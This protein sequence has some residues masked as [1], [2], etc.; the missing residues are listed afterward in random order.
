[1]IL[2]GLFFIAVIGTI[3]FYIWKRLVK[4]TQLKPPYK[5]IATLLIVA[6]ALSIPATMVISRAV[7]LDIVKT[8]STLPLLWLG[9]MLLIVTFLFLVDIFILIRHLIGWVASKSIGS[10]TGPTDPSRRE[11]LRKITAA[12]TLGMTGVLTTTSFHNVQKDATVIKQRLTLSKLP[13][14]LNGLRIA[15]I[16]D[17]HIGL[18]IDGNFLSRAVRQVNALSPDIVVVTGDLV[19]G[20]VHQLKHEVHSL[21]ELV[22]PLGVYFVTGNHEYYFNADEWIT[23]LTNMGIKVLDNRAVEIGDGPYPLILAG[24]NDFQAN[25]STGD[26]G[27]DLKKALAHRHPKQEVILLCHQPKIIKD[28]AAADVGLILSGHTHGGQIWPFNYLVLLQQPYLKGLINYN[29]RTKMYINQGTG[30]WGPPMRL[31]TES[32]ITLFT[33]YQDKH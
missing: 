27:P 21:T 8:V 13:R 15:Q 31:G 14:R 12:G 33:L 30:Y 2:F 3:H 18:T 23:H 9:A 29:Q 26:E 20:Y 10:S 7:S 17:I 4:N 19:D 24:V 6:L 22:A 28:A 32:E 11:S 1:M 25:R 16:S 5:I